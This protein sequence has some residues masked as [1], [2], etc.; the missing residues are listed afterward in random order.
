MWGWF[1]SLTTWY[2]PA[3]CGFGDWVRWGVERPSYVETTALG[4]ALAAGLGTG[5]YRD[6]ADL[7][8]QVCTHARLGLD[9][10]WLCDTRLTSFGLCVRAYV[11]VCVVLDW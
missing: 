6:L 9:D 5:V 7:R 3:F 4:A 2:L 10:G 1:L 11:C 8:S